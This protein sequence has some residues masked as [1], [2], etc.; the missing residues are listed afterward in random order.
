MQ[1]HPYADLFPMMTA[2]ELEALAT[3]VAEHG[4]RHPIVRYGGKVLDGRN[5]LLACKRAGVE[6]TFADHEGDDASALALVISL[7]TQR[8][9][10]TAAQRA[11]VA[12]RTWGLSGYSKGGRPEKGKPV[13]SS[14]VSLDSLA[15]QFRVSKPSILQARDLLA[16]APDLVSQ[17]EACAL[18]LAGAY[19]QLQERDREERRKQREAEQKARDAEKAAHYRDAISSGEM[20]LDDAIAAIRE[21]EREARLKLEAETDARSGWLKDLVAM[22]EWA[23]RHVP[24]NPEFAAWNLLPNTPGWF[25]HGVTAR[26]LADVVARL[27]IVRAALTQGDLT[28]GQP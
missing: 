28:N 15:K 16:S 4:L 2:D 10:L 8:R 9:D 24:A 17:V 21:E 14:P 22:A 6:P 20:K 27:E 12:A 18:S 11:I 5:R 19:Q 3:D 26:R 1:S 23:E 7:N 13:K 25:D